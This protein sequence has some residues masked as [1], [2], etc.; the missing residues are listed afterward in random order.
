MMKYCWGGMEQ[1]MGTD[2]LENSIFFGILNQQQ[3]K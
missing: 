3:D 1:A 2:E